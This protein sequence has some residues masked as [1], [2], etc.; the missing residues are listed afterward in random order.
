MWLCHTKELLEQAKQRCEETIECKTSTITEGKCDVSGD[1]VFGTIQTVVNY[2][3][4]DFLKQNDFGMVIADEVHRVN[5]NP[6]TFQMYRKSIEY[7]ASKYR[8]GLTATKFRSD[9]LEQCLNNI[10][11]ED[12]Y[13]IEKQGSDYCCIYENKVLLRFPVDKFQVPAYIKVIETKYNI[14]DKEVYAPNGGTIQY[15]TLISDL[16]MNE[17]RNKQI[18]KH[19]KKIKGS[20]IVLSDRVDQLKYLCSQVENGVQIDGGTPKKIRKQAIDDVR[21]GKYKFLFASYNLCREGLDIPILSNLVMATPVKN[22]ATVV[23]SIGRIQRPYEGKT[24]ATVYDFTDD[25]GMLLGFFSKR[26]AIYR[27]NNWSIENMFLEGDV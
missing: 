11:G 2:I 26:R 16:A 5:A 19:L 4:N 1:I 23:Q 15:A 8:I 25:V 6:N 9:G 27:K 10:L 18:I 20:T 24:I 21:S 14:V 17:K 13:C 22:F 3:D 12:I 7:F